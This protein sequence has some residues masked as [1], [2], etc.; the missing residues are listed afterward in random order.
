MKPAALS[1]YESK[2]DRPSQPAERHA[3]LND[4]RFR[5][6]LVEFDLL[7]DKFLSESDA[8]I[9]DRVILDLVMKYLLT[10]RYIINDDDSQTFRNR[11][12]KILKLKTVKFEE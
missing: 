3:C 1:S 2:L 10:K 6:L 8:E 4:S 12:T 11:Q 9:G 7:L 5:T